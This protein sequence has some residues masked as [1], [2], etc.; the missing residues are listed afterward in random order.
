V[1]G[2]FVPLDEVA[3]MA[4]REPFCP[5]GL[6]VFERWR[7]WAGIRTA[8]GRDAAWAGELVRGAFAPFVARIGREPAPMREDVGEAISRAEVY[9]TDERDG[10]IELVPGADHL[11]VPV[12]AVRPAS[13]GRGVG[14]R[15]LRFAE[16]RA[17][18]LGLRELR[19]FTN[20]AMV[21]NRRWYLGLGYEET[22]RETQE[23]Y[24]RVFFRRLL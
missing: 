14:S 12:V 1:W 24:D 4:A 23:G 13:Q 17:A 21:E 16:T 7:R 3:A 19:L 6:E 10:V 20:A 22:G 18:E 2:G 15:M 11:L 5:D 8:T 9:V